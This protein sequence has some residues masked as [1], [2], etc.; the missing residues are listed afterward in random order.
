MILW[1]VSGI[2]LTPGQSFINVK[3]TG[4]VFTVDYSIDPVTQELSLNSRGGEQYS[5]PVEVTATEPGGG[6]PD[7][8]NR[9]SLTVRL[10]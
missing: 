7:N 1:K 6:N 9:T 10:L 5:V 2:S 4:G 8:K 3:G